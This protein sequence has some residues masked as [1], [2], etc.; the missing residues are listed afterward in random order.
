M[1]QGPGARTNRQRRGASNGGQTEARPRGSRPRRSPERGGAESQRVVRDTRRRRRGCRK[2]T[3][4]GGRKPSIGCGVGTRVPVAPCRHRRGAAGVGSVYAA[5]RADP[6]RWEAPW[7]RRAVQLVGAKPAGQVRRS[8]EGAPGIAKAPRND[9]S[10][11]APAPLR[12]RVEPDHGSSVSETGSR[13]PCAQAA[14]LAAPRC[15]HAAPIS[16]DG[17]AIV[18]GGAFVYPPGVGRQRPET[19]RQASSNPR[20]RI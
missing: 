2:A 11:P 19:S 7:S 12:K 1:A 10:G 20:N 18:A 9:P 5:K 3:R 14:Q 15:E 6:H 4:F 8:P 17:G 16:R 13:Q